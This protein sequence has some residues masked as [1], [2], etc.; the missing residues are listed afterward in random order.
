M[1]LNTLIEELGDLDKMNDDNNKLRK[2]LGFYERQNI[3]L[4]EAISRCSQKDEQ[5]HTIHMLQIELNDKNKRI[6]ELTEEL[7][8][9]KNGSRQASKY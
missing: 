2:I 6:F 3:L 5:T 9:L 1:K 4:V 7:I 8:A